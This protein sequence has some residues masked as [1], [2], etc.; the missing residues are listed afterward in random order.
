MKSVIPILYNLVSIDAN[1]DE[2]DVLDQVSAV[3]EALLELGYEPL[4]LSFSEKIIDTVDVLNKIKPPLVFNLT[5]STAQKGRL[6]YVAPSI[7]EVL[8]I[9]YTGCS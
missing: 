8:N 7:L 6:S 5:E 3:S 9:P 4:Q 2:A 1:T